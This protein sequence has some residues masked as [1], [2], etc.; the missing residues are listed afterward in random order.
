MGGLIGFINGGTI[1]ESSSS[2]TVQ[3][4]TNV[5]GLVGF[6]GYGNA[7]IRFSF[8]AS[9][10][11]PASGGGNRNQFGGL[12]GALQSGTI[13]NSFAR[14]DV[15]GNNRVGGLVGENRWGNINN[16]FSTGSIN[17]EAGH[18]G[19]LVGRDQGGS[20]ANSF[21]D[22]ETSGS[23]NSAAGTGKTTAEMTAEATFTNAGWDFENIWSIDPAINNGYP[24]LRAFFPVVEGDF[25]SRQSGPWNDPDTWSIG[26]HSGAAAGTSPGEDHNA[27]IGENHVVTLTA[28][29]N[30]G[31]G[32]TLVNNTGR[33]VTQNHILS[34]SGSFSL[35]AGG[36]LHIGSPEGI[37]SAAAAG[38]IQTS[39]AR[40][41]S[42]QAN[43]VYDGSSA[44]QTGD[45][46]PATVNNLRIDNANGVTRLGSLR[47]NG[48]LQLDHGLFS[49][50]PGSSLVANDI[51]EGSGTIRM[52]LTIAGLKGWRMISSPVGTTYGDLFD[53]FVTQGFPGSDHASL[54]PNILWFDE[55][56]I[57]TTNMAWRAPQNISEALTGGR[58]HFFYV[59]DGAGMPN[60][61]GNY[62]DELPI[63][64]DATGLEY[65]TGGG[66]FDFGLT[67][68]PRSEDDITDTDIVEM[69]TG[70]NLVG[71]PST[72]SLNWNSSGWTKEHVDESIYIWDPASES[73]LIWNGENG[74]TESTLIAPFQAFWVRASNPNPV[75]SM[76]DEVKT[77]GGSFVGGD[78]VPDKE[79][80]TISHMAIRMLLE[81]ESRKTTSFIS[82]NHEG[83]LAEDRY[84]AYQ[85]EPMSD[86]WV[87]LYTT[88]R[89]HGMPMVINNLPFA[90]VQLTEIPVYVEGQEN[91]QGISG[92]YT[93][94][95]QLPDSWPASWLA[96]LMD[97]KNKTATPMDATG[98]IDH[99][100]I[101]TPKGAAAS[102]PM[103][104]ELTP[105]QSIIG[106]HTE[107]FSGSGR[108]S[109]PFG[110][111][112]TAGGVKTAQVNTGPRF[113]IV[114]SPGT[115][116]EHP[117][118]MAPEASILPV[119]PN[120]VRDVASIRFS[121]PEESFVSI[122]VYD[123]QGRLLQ[124]LIS[125]IMPAGV[126]STTWAPHLN[127]ANGIYLAV[128]RTK[129]GKQHQ[130]MILAR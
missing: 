56:E 65:A 130:K 117:G 76:N 4:T 66:T 50:S 8:S 87:K 68:T 2:G 5:G 109:K 40:A 98:S 36:T 16:S 95:W 47:V 126:H 97:H 91:L 118:Y 84:D 127:L 63:T 92:P 82:F 105:P 20:T 69:N 104:Q 22:V 23:S 35:A 54:Q 64:M 129:D 113:S 125:Q 123:L 13:E 6:A 17:S 108:P 53:N 1:E 72:A 41:F 14:G 103:G 96:T 71:N 49:M 31:D 79:E 58:G 21:W 74:N 107:G 43:Y 128:M 114:I 59:F 26:S 55:T 48:Q 89:E 115:T 29:V 86:S 45:G 102:A 42:Q 10:V 78:H 119:Y 27:T 112:N 12:V 60:G 44:Q 61:Q 32:S 3:G 57:G 73:F 122:E 18:S 81:T 11:M 37:R 7:L 83:S 116:T 77:T 99:F 15:M 25:F 75:L 93:L 111:G 85:L 121:L 34:G 9:D 90:L 24:F 106:G 33:L 67:H 62:P 80:G 94:S 30:I 70:W 51:D 39:G 28:D 19:G 100:S 52:Q 124:E 101:D 120:P 110:F 88:T 46:L 38:S